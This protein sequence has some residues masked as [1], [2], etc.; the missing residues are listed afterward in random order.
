MI[1]FQIVDPAI[2]IPQF[3]KFPFSFKFHYIRKGVIKILYLKIVTARA[4][5]NHRIRGAFLRGLLGDFDILASNQERCT[6]CG[7]SVEICLVQVIKMESDFPVVD[8]EWCIGCGVCALPRPT[9]AI[10]VET[11][12][13]YTSPAG[14]N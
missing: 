11:S 8:K 12:Q 2:E 6:G 9:S 10:K 3:F 14:N 4:G 13:K 1:P 7:Q 5:V